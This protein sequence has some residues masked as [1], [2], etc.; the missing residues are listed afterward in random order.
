MGL[1]EFIQ[2]I[3]NSFK[4]VPFDPSCFD[5]PTASKVSWSPKK[6]G[7][8]SY[9]TRTLNTESSSK[10]VYKGS[11]RGKM[12]GSIFIIVPIIIMASVFISIDEL[13]ADLSD[14][15]GF[16]IPLT[17]LTIGIFVIYYSNRPIVID[18]QLG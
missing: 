17:V 12:L 1:S 11:K 10:L 2:S 3:K 9:K 7:G 16:F 8:T 13:A 4:V 5:H 14:L 15:S 6:G 18:K